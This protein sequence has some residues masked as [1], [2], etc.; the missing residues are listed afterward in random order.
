[1]LATRDRRA[2]VDDD[3]TRH[4]RCCATTDGQTS[5]TSRSPSGHRRQGIADLVCLHHARTW[6]RLGGTRN[7]I[8]YLTDDQLAQRSTSGTIANGFRRTQPHAGVMVRHVSW[9]SPVGDR[10][11][12][13]E[14]SPV[15]MMNE[16][17]NG[18]APLPS[19]APL[20]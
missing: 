14:T 13:F 15:V 20:W 2:R 18:M 1:M 9:L 11:P 12:G 16:A 19:N 4:G 5:A 10:R 3:F 8:G 17:H 7:L 6:L